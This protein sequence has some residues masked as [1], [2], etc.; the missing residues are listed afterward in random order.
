[1]PRS[2]SVAPSEPSH[3]SPHVPPQPT[4]PLLASE[5]L[6]DDAAPLQPGRRAARLW[7]G[8]ATLLLVALGYAFWQG[9]G[10]PG[11][12]SESALLSLSAAFAFAT[13]AALPFPYAVRALL[14]LVVSAVGITLGLRGAGPLAGLAVDG[15]TARDV[16]R[17]VAVLSL[18]AALM[19]RGRYADF[20][21]SGALL[22]GAL[23]LA[24]PFVVAEGMLASDVSATLS[25]R[26]WAALNSLLVLACLLGLLPA[27]AGPGSDILAALLLVLVPG[28][29]ALRAWTPL[30]GPEAGP[31]TYPLTAAAFVAL[32]L[33]ASLGLFQLLA[34]A[35]GP[36]ARVESARQR[37]ASE[38]ESRSSLPEIPEGDVE[39][40]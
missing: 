15:G 24:L 28:E 16:T 37:V 8:V 3:P 14:T 20:T 35:L 34:W 39:Q 2:L 32:A 23:L 9:A 38:R 21:R 36:A 12:N 11:L 40:P 27:A 4:R 26:A 1:M 30:A 18:A 13:I 22:L 31:L 25:L 6:R 5:V 10:V 19:F 33:P 7:L 29:L 17:V